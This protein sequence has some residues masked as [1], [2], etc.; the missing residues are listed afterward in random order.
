MRCRRRQDEPGE[1]R[2]DLRFVDA[3]G[4]EERG[5]DV[6]MRCR[7]LVDE[8]A[9]CRVGTDSSDGERDTGG[10]VVELEP[11]LMEATVG[12]KQFAVVGCANDDRL[13]RAVV[14]DS[15]SDLFERAVNLG[16]EPV[17]ELP[18]LGRVAFICVV[19]QR[20]GAVATRI[21]LSY[22]IWA[23]GFDARSS[24][25]VGDSS[26]VG[27][28]IGEFLSGL[29]RSHAGHNTMSWGFTKLATRRN[30]FN[31]SASPARRRA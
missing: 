2:R 5:D 6:D 23:A 28:C 8:G 22:A 3:G 19:D 29:R 17:V 4:G 27:S 18:I 15:P 26:M 13:F 24:L 25:S 11:L 16:V 20:D 1:R 12:P 9:G 21:R 10:F 14:R 7:C 31:A 30:G